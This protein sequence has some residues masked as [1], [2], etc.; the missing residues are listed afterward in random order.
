MARQRE[1]AGPFGWSRRSTY[2]EV[3]GGFFPA[4]SRDFVAYLSALIQAAQTRS[5][6]GRDM[7]EHVLAARVGLDKSIALCRIEP[8]HCTYCHVVSPHGFLERD[9]MVTEIRRNKGQC[10]LARKSR[11]RVE[12]ATALLLLSRS[13]VLII[14]LA[15]IVGLYIA[16][17]LALRHFFPTDS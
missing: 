9:K 6:D 11:R 2:S 12:T 16:V 17:R 1:P 7:D 8:L 10:N 5:L 15:I 4:V 14:G 3:F 13:N